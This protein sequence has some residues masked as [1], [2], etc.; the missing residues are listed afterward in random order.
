M[1]HGRGADEHDL[2]DVAEALPGA[3]A[4]ASLRAPVAVPGGG[5]T[6]YQSGSGPGTPTAESLRASIA[7]VRAWLDGAETAALDRGRCYLLGFSAGMMM[8][9]A[10]LLDDPARFAGAVLLSG[11]IA[12]DASVDASPGRLAGKPVFHA[13]GTRDTVIPA[14]RVARTTR[15]LREESRAELTERTYP[16]GHSISE[17]ELADVRAWLDQ[18]TSIDP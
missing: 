4:F 14:D 1:L 8:A 3:F 5:Y 7:G 12:F 13:H 15:Y 9:S 2:I 6:W 18:F 16:Q 11:A 10:L 17:R